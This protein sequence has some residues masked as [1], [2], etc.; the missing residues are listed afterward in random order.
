[1]KH[2]GRL[3]QTYFGLG[4]LLSSPKRKK[5]ILESLF[6]ELN[7]ENNFPSILK[8]LANLCQFRKPENYNYKR[9]L[10]IFSC[11]I[12]L[13]LIAQESHM[14]NKVL[15]CLIIIEQLDKHLSQF[16]HTALNLE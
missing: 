2:V 9:T 10:I 13:G 14:I 15:F 4:K 11:V 5:E 12:Q 8:D 1:M 3:M 6:L 16:P 7:N